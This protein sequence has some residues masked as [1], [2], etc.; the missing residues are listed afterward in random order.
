MMLIVGLKAAVTATVL[1][2]ETAQSPLLASSVRPTLKGVV[3]Q[4]AAVVLHW[5]VKL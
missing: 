1:V 5:I 2:R 4:V 3:G